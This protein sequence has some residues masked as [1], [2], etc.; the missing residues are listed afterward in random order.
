MSEA[1][2]GLIIAHAS[3]AEG[4]A[5]AV[6]RI[7]GVGADVLRPLSNEG[8]G[9]DALAAE[10]AKVAGEAPVILFADL[11]GGSCA[12]AARKMALQRPGTAVICGVNLPVLVEFVFRRDLPLGALVERLIE[13]GRGSISGAWLEE[14]AHADRAVS[15]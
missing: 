4:L 15:R 14:T 11:G 8:R 9:P 13:A 2:L 3:L 10:I 6:E 7:T 12:F 5:S 1:V